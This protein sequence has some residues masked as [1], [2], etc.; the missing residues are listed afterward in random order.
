MGGARTSLKVA[1][2]RVAAVV[3]QSYWLA[4]ARSM[5]WLNVLKDNRC[6]FA[7][8]NVSVSNSLALSSAFP[9]AGNP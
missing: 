9:P 2:W 8:T 1:R 6:Y 7:R 4:T 3:R 5:T